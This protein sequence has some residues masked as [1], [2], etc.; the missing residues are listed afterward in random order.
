MMSDRNTGTAS[1]WWGTLAQSLEEL[2]GP[3]EQARE[4]A[5]TRQDTLTKPQGAL[6]KRPPPVRCSSRIYALDNN[7]ERMAEDHANA[8]MLAESL[9]PLPG[10]HVEPDHV[11]T[12]IIIIDVSASGA[13]ATTWSKRLGDEGV[14]MSGIGPKTLRALTHLDVTSEECQR[15]A[16][17][18]ATLATGEFAPA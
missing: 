16:E 2:P 3:D 11:E 12:N 15:A 18:F 1:H 10:L 6:G 17:I 7:V 13:D 8:K 14:R 9:A 4:A 5:R